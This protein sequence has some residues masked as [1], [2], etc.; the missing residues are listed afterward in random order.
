MT[1][2][3][4]QTASRLSKGKDPRLPVSVPPLPG[5]EPKRKQGET[6]G[7]GQQGWE[8]AVQRWWGRNMVGRGG[9]GSRPGPWACHKMEAK[10]R[11][12]RPGGKGSSRAQ[13][14]GH[15]DLG[16]R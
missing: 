16:A 12:W 9:A 15:L 10:G 11:K 8:L 7:Q 3:D 2:G 6:E 14:K 1:G 5:S 4:Q 13:E